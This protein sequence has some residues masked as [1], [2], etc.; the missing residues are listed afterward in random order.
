MISPNEDRQTELDNSKSR[1]SLYLKH[2]LL[3]MFHKFQSDYSQIHIG[4]SLLRFKLRD[5]VSRIFCRKPD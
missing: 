2:V 1:T 5:L 4:V 3:H